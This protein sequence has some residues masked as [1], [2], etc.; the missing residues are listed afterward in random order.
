VQL[1]SG[2]GLAWTVIL[3]A[4]AEFTGS[5]LNRTIVVNAAASVE[6]LLRRLRP[7]GDYLQTVGVAGF[8][9]QD[10]EQLAIGLAEIGA[11]RITPIPAMPWPPATWHHDGR[12]PLRELVRWTDLEPVAGMDPDAAPPAA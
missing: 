4:A 10:V 5:C 2:E 3:D 7:L 8:A 11:T 12:G 9:P 1:W 6:D